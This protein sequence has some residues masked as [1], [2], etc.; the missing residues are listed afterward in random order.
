MRHSGK[1]QNALSKR[2]KNELNS[3]QKSKWKML[4]NAKNV[5]PAEAVPWEGGSVSKK[6]EPRFSARRKKRKRPE[7]RQTLRRC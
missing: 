7:R 5:R 6:E 1:S 2:R 4:E 3:W